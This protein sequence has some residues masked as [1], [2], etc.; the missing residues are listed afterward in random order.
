MKS[1][2]G[3]TTTRSPGGAGSIPLRWAYFDD[4]P[5][6]FRDVV[7]GFVALGKEFLAGRIN[8]ALR[9][10]WGK[11]EDIQYSLKHDN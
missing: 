11:L 2:Y 1:F 4:R 5:N 9:K 3:R 7:R 6:R 10:C 8:G